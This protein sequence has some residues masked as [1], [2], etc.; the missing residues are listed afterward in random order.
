MCEVAQRLGATPAAISKHIAVLLASG[1]VRR[2][3]GTHYAIDPRF[4]VPG[5]RAI[6]IGHALLRF[7]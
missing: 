6:E 3:Y 5:E 2:S 7:G 1:I 4:L